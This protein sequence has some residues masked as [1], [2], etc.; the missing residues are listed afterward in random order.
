VKHCGRSAF[1]HLRRAWALHGA[2]NEM[3][4]FRAITAEEEA[5][6]AL[7]LSLQQK[8][9]PGAGRLNFRDHLH[10]AAPTPFFNAVAK[11]LA[12]MDFAKPTLRLSP[13]ADPP[14][15]TFF[16]D[17]SR[18]GLRSPEPLF[19]EP[20]EPL[21]F[22]IRMEGKDGTSGVHMFEEQL[23]EVTQGNSLDEIVAFLRQEANRRKQLLHATDTGI[24]GVTFTKGFLLERLRRM[25]V[26]L[27]LTV[28]IQPTP[29]HQLFAV[30]CLKAF[31]RAL[32]KMDGEPFD[33][34]E[35]EPAN[36]GIVL[37]KEP[38][39]EPVAC[40]AG[41]TPSEPPSDTNCCR[42]CT[43]VGTTRGHP[44]DLPGNRPLRH[45]GRGSQPSRAAL[46]AWMENLGWSPR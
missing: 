27:T 2:D 28:A 43:S 14:H 21:N 40:S 10:K 19:A 1:N 15:V 41:A 26:L 3:S 22:V 39:G 37:H 18:T 17:L 42:C 45:E 12:F 11:V 7:I 6:S 36:L 16:V 8:R 46:S 4:A 33:F 23:R 44:A 9:Y 29:T 5:A 32:R 34:G 38:D 35:V 25:A 31:L 30:Q 13:D 24:P 20:D